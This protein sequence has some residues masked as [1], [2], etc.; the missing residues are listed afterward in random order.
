[1]VPDTL[2]L[3]LASFFS[4]RLCRESDG[5]APSSISGT[6]LALSILVLWPS[7]AGMVPLN[8]SVHQLFFLA[9][10]QRQI[11]LSSLRS[12]HLMHEC[13][14]HCGCFARIQKKCATAETFRKYLCSIK[15]QEL[16]ILGLFCAWLLP[17]TDLIHS[18]YLRRCPPFRIYVHPILMEA[19]W[20]V[21]PKMYLEPC[22]AEMLFAVPNQ[23][24]WNGVTWQPV[25]SQILPAFLFQS[26]LRLG[27]MRQEWC[28]E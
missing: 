1:M 24:S 27:K 28:E 14:F 7:G 5:T 26:C 16:F 19:K 2:V 23:N 3:I 8:L 20:W 25:A 11:L 18:P 10:C 9:L 13:C 22:V 17:G 12:L 4:L 15:L 6:Q 21:V